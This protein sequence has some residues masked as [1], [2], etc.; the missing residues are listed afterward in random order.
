MAVASKYNKYSATPSAA[1]VALRE[2]AL[3]V[4]D[5]DGVAAAC[6]A[7]QDRFGLDVDVLLLAAYVGGVRRHGLT[8]E[9][10]ATARTL[11]DQ[12]HIE[13]VRAL[14]DV[15][16]LLK[17]GPAP[18]PSPQTEDVRKQVAKAELE[19]ELIELDMLDG[20]AAELQGVPDARRP[21][22]LAAAAMEV[23]LRSYSDDSPDDDARR[24]LA[25]IATAAAHGDEAT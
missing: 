24:H 22:E 19:A 15:R 8:M 21:A 23:A 16:R 3:A 4:H 6:I 10:L 2:F 5:A 20:W 17:S 1:R 7:L 9:E 11:V 18:A 14:R 13:V 25:T 12:W